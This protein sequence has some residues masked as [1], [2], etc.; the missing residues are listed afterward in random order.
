MNKEQLT[1][2]PK[3]STGAIVALIVPVIIWMVYIFGIAICGYAGYYEDLSPILSDIGGIAFMAFNCAF[4]F[5]IPITIAV[6]FLAI[7]EIKKSNG[8]LTGYRL[9]VEGIIL[10]FILIP[11]TFAF[12]IKWLAPC[13][14]IIFFPL[15]DF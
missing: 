6:S 15:S 8:K 13:G 3:T 10:S 4:A 2:N 12:L 1:G 14:K 11:L 5:F 7:S 9:V